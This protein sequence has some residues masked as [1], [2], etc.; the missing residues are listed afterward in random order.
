MFRSKPSSSNTSSKASSSA[1]NAADKLKAAREKAL[2]IKQ[3]QEEALAALPLNKLYIVLWIRNDPPIANDF[4]W[5]MYYHKTKKAGTKYHM[6]NLGPGWIA[7]HGTTS[8][9]FKS[10]FLCVL[11]EIGTISADNEGTLDRIMRSYDDTANTIPGFTCRVWVLMIL[12][13]LIQ[14]GLLRC[15]DLA[16]L[17]QECFIFG[18]ECMNAAAGNDQPRPVRVSRRC[19]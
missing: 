17:E 16:G 7:D 18:N 4:H 12:P 15:S 11:I 19:L 9:V 14:L 6:K 5:G 8:G 2:Q 1:T 3:L 10:Q 13:H